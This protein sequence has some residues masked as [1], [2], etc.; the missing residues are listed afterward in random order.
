MRDM[1]LGGHGSPTMTIASTAEDGRWIF[2]LVN[3]LDP[4][5]IFFTL[6]SSRSSFIDSTLQRNTF[7]TFFSDNFAEEVELSSLTSS[8]SLLTAALRHCLL[9]NPSMR[10]E[11]FVLETTFLP[12]RCCV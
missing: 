1:R 6:A 8:K 2:Y 4:I 10:Y 11:G 9:P 3:L 5:K 12:H 7:R